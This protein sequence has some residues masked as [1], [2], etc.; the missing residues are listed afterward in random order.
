MTIKA[1]LVPS[2]SEKKLKKFCV[3]LHL[4]ETWSFGQEVSATPIDD[5]MHYC[6]KNK[7]KYNYSCLNFYI[8]VVGYHL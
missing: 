2:L 5:P 7:V 6:S 3:P 8:Y 1:I 4:N